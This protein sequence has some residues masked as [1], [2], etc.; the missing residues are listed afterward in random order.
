[1]RG[2]LGMSVENLQEISAMAEEIITTKKDMIETPVGIDD[3][4]GDLV[5]ETEVENGARERRNA[6]S[7][8]RHREASRGPEALWGQ[9]LLTET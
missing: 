7:T 9:T 8:K 1:M 2:D 5:Q 4:G 6:E 3:E